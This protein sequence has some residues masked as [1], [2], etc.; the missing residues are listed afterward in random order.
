M[1]DIRHLITIASIPDAIYPLV[2]SGAGF[3]RWW[4]EDI[5]ENGDLAELGFFNRQ[6][7]YR[8]R[9]VASEPPL[10]VE[11]ICETGHE[12][13]GTTITF[14]LEPSGSNTRLRFTHGNWQEETEYFTDCNTTWGGLMWRLKAAAEG[15][16]QGPLFTMA[17]L[18]DQ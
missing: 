10:K 6:T 11:W 8:L 7:V 2:S 17:G 13:S 1:A 16:P 15:S 3:S 9:R 18:A 4:A 14:V 12:W 5:Q